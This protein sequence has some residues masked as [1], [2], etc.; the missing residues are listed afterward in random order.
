MV[1]IGGDDGDATTGA[2]N[3]LRATTSNAIGR[4]DFTEN[5]LWKLSRAKVAGTGRNAVDLGRP[6]V[7]RRTSADG[8]RYQA[9]AKGPGCSTEPVV[10]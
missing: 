5:P 10:L 2:A 6:R 9:I 4:A 1:A 8:H 3:A 7:G